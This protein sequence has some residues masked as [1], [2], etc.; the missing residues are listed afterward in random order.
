M[1]LRTKKASRVLT[2]EQQKHLTEVGVNSMAAFAESREWQREHDDP[3]IECRFIEIR[4][5]ADDE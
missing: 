5:E 4:L 1:S 2:K 3:C